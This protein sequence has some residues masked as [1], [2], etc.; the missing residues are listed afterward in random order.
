MNK[1]RLYYKDQNNQLS[2]FAN[3]KEYK[4][5]CKIHSKD[6]DLIKV[7]GYEEALALQ[8]ALKT[9][10]QR[11]SEIR[12][13]YDREIQKVCTAH[14]LNDINSARNLSALAIS[15]LQAIAK[16][17]TGWELAQQATFIA[18][19]RDAENDII[20]IENSTFDDNFIEFN[21]DTQF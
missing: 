4:I 19:L 9:T 12:Y 13:K 7:G 10:E 14:L 8:E 18:L 21:K 3:D 11:I 2:S 20:T 1:N 6:N 16:K 5:Y 17:I 15:P